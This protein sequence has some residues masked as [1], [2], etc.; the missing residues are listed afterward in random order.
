MISIF[1]IPKDRTLVL[2]VLILPIAYTLKLRTTPVPIS[3]NIGK[4]IPG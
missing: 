4:H 3:K 2:R 1:R